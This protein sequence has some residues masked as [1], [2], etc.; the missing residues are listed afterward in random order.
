[1]KRLLLC[2]VVTNSTE[3]LHP[4]SGSA[5]KSSL[6]AAGPRAGPHPAAG[7]QG[8]QSHQRKEQC[9]G[10]QLCFVLSPSPPEG[11][12]SAGM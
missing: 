12:V 11:N 2:A 4:D 5:S 1:M 7:Q 6:V 10:Q 3:C 8:Q 9:M